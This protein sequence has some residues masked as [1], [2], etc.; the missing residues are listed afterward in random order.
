MDGLIAARVLH[1]LGVVLWIGGVALVTTVLLPA[2][3]RMKTPDERVEFFESIERRFASQAR[4]V[5][6]V[7][8]ASGLY[9]VYGFDL[10]QRF[11]RLEYWW[12]HAM[13]AIWAV[14]TLMLFVIEPLA[15][16]RSSTKL[17]KIG[18]DEADA[19]AA[20]D[21][22]RM[23]V[24]I[25]RMHWVLLALSIVTVAGAVAGSHGYLLFAG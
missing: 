18:A 12:M 20:R 3:K 7:T 9:L 11:A 16:R 8:G 10:W 21:P 4:V 5:T 25:V 2:A 23:F 13:V 14:F 24:R 17:T 6:L 19:H 1:V 22:E 15:H